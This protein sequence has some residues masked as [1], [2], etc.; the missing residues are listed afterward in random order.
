M[1]KTGLVLAGLLIV[2]SVVSAQARQTGHFTFEERGEVVGKLYRLGLENKPEHIPVFCEAL[3]DKNSAVRE[4]AI[5]QL[6]FTHD[7][8]AI[9]PVIGVMK[10]RSRRVRRS[11]IAVLERIGSK[12]AI[13]ALK[14]ALT[15][16]PS[17]YK[18]DE[19][20][21]PEEYF[22]RLAAAMALHRLGSKAGRGTVLEALRNPSHKSVQ[23]MAL[24]AVIVM[25]MK[26]ATSE[27][28]RIARDWEFFGEDSPGFFA[29]RTIW[30]VADEKYREEIVEVA[31]QKSSAIGMH[32]PIWSLALLVKFGDEDVADV[33]KQ[34]ISTTRSHEH[35]YQDILGLEKFKP[36]GSA[37]LIC[38]Y[39]L[40]P[41]ERDTKT[42]EIRWQREY[43]VFRM[44][45][46]ALATIGDK[47]VVPEIRKYYGIYSK[48]DDW[49]Y[50]R[51]WLAWTL[52]RLGDEEGRDNLETA[53]KHDDAAVRRIAA[54]LL[55]KLGDRNVVALLVEA[56]KKETEPYT[57][58][59]M[60]AGIKQLGPVSV[61]VRA[62][63]EPVEAPAPED[64]Y[65]KPRYFHM[66]FDDCATP[67]SLER[68]SN[69]VEEFASQDIRWVFTMAYAPLSRYDY[70]YNAVLVQRCFDRGCEI[71]NHTL[72]HNPDG[73]GLRGSTDDQLRAEIGGCNNWISSHI[74]GADKIYRWYGGGGPLRRPG[75][76]VRSWRDI[77]E[78]ASEANFAKD[79]SIWYRVPVFS[80]LDM[81][82]PPFHLHPKNDRW[83]GFKEADRP[84]LVSPRC[85]G[86]LRY[87]YD[88]EDPAERIRSFAASFD[89]WYFN[90]P[91]RVLKIGG[92]DWPNAP[93]PDRPGNEVHWEILSGFLK[94]VL[95]NRK[96]R[97]RLIRPMTNLELA[98]IFKRKVDPE[99]LITREVHLQTDTK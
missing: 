69:L 29:L 21:R 57:F 14:K 89:Y 47:S 37:E 27:C 53:L 63:P 5:A 13:P 59:V 16:R 86:D 41:K 95:L 7:E 23:A 51:L 66:W 56:L 71:T 84:W 76:P 88:A 34:N 8:T 70:E 43:K 19:S 26:K 18:K 90:R 10:D 97:Y 12:K 61:E 22:N 9:K 48:P 52:A 81:F 68:F 2:V 39:V 1:R 24:K 28:I 20:L 54:K 55:V 35:L 58:K 46:E 33:F 31:R 67:G 15:Y 65:G 45:C 40:P 42:G 92:H 87:A 75:D 80:G 44:G 79:L 36:E 73:R 82:A 49:Y 6:V 38:K 17:D 60:K 62:L 72:H 91:N 32:A 64:T 94:E 83:A 3:K 50:Y 98:H 78:I 30:H 93:I 11:A 77:R 4:V 74:R 96:D 85:L 99:K 25:D